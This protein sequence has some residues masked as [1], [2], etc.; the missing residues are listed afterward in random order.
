MGNQPDTELVLPEAETHLVEVRII[1][2]AAEILIFHQYSV[3]IFFL[4]LPVVKEVLAV[5]LA[6][7]LGVHAKEKILIILCELIFFQQPVVM[8]K[9]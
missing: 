6:L 3:A 4:N 2:P 7:L 5:A 1:M 8:R 9:P